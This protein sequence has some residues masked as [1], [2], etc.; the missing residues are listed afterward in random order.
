[1]DSISAVLGF[2]ICGVALWG[3]HENNVEYQNNSINEKYRIRRNRIFILQGII[4]FVW[5]LH[6]LRLINFNK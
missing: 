2:A 5:G 6:G 3:I 1:M 4:G